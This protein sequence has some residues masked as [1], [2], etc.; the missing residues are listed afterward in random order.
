MHGLATWHVA[1]HL[2]VPGIGIV[3]MYAV[4]A[5][6]AIEPKRQ[7]VERKLG[8]HKVGPVGVLIA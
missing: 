3:V 5:A 6:V 4:L 1:E 8:S 7:A 2:P